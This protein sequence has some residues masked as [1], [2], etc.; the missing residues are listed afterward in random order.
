ML[1]STE[2]NARRQ[3]LPDHSNTLKSAQA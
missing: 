2:K 3:R 1:S